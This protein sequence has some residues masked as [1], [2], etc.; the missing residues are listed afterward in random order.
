MLTL[1]VALCSSCASH[2]TAARMSRLEKFYQIRVGMSHEEVYQRLGKSQGGFAQGVKDVNTEVW[3]D[4]PD[5]SGRVNRLS[6]LFGS[7]GH[8]WSVEQDTVVLK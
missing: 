8:A 4:E 7:Y 6:I 2:Q 5:K 3:V 1:F